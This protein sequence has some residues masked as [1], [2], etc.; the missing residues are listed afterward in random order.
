MVPEIEKIFFEPHKIML[1]FTSEAVNFLVREDYNP[2]YGVRELCCTLER[3]I[4]VP[5]S[6]FI[7]SGGLE[8]QSNWQTKMTNGKLVIV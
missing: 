7:L 1:T 2:Q 4:Q 5:L 8:K 3:Q 6:R